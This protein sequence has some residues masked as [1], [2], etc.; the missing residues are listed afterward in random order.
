MRQQCARLGLPVQFLT[1]LSILQATS[2]TNLYGFEASTD[3]ALSEQ[4]TCMLAC[5]EE[6]LCPGSSEPDYLDSQCPAPAS[7]ANARPSVSGGGACAS[8]SALASGAAV[9]RLQEVQ[10]LL[11]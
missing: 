6:L 1:R 11:R 8:L 5:N 4:D 9:G 2:L 3:S 7:A 10:E